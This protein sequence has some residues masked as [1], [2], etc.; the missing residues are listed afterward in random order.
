[1]STRS[2]IAEF[3]GQTH[4]FFWR[5]ILALWQHH[6]VGAQIISM[7]LAP[8]PVPHDWVAK[9]AAIQLHPLPLARLAAVALRPTRYLQMRAILRR[10]RSLAFVLMVPELARIGKAQALTLLHMHSRTNFALITAMCSGIAGIPYS[11][12]L[13]G[14]LADCGPD[15]PV[16]WQ[17]AD[18]VFIITELFACR[19]RKSCRR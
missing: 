10:C 4:S 5:E 8:Q 17:G 6:G 2:K 9:G 13:H 14:P 3:P 18:F 12:V 19:W 16:K 11:F 7:R 15:Q 1:M